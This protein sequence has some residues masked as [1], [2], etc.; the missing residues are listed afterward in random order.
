MMSD[1][2]ISI[3]LAAVVA[4]VVSVPASPATYEVNEMTDEI[5]GPCTILHCTL[6]EAIIDANNNPGADTISITPSA[7]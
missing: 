2:R 1:H 6:R 5:S 7:R 3:V 4:V